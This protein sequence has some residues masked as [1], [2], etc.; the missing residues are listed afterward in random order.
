M[1][2]SSFASQ[3]GIRLRTTELSWDEFSSLFAGLLPETPLSQIVNIRSEKDPKVIKDFN[4]SQ[5]RIYN[6]WKSKRQASIRDIENMQKDMESLSS[7]LQEM[8]G[9]KR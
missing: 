3:Y 1:I 5:R 2:E 9:E 7:L 6:E 8:F 4:E